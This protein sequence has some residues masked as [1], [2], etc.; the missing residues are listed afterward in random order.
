M[1]KYGLSI[2]LDRSLVG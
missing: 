1:Q 2:Y